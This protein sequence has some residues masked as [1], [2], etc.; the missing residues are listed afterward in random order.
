MARKNKFDL[1]GQCHTVVPNNPEVILDSGSSLSLVKDKVLFVD[2]VVVK[3]KNSIII[4]TNAGNKNIDEQGEVIDYR[5]SFY[6]ESTL[7]NIF[8]MSNMVRK[9]NMVFID[10]DIDN[11]FIFANKQSGRVTKFPCDDRGLYVR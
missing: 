7:T 1:A 6:D 3:C 5:T 10:T 4:E 8:G 2:K 9:G 11:S